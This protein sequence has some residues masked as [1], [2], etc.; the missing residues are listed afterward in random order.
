M[1]NRR[2]WVAEPLEGREL[3]SGLTF[4]LETDQTTYQVGQPIV[5]TFTETNGGDQP[6]TVEVLPTDFTVTLED[7]SFAAPVWQ[8]NPENQGAASTSEALQPGESLTQTVTWDGSSTELFGSPSDLYGTYAVTNPNAPQGTSASF[9]IASPIEDRLTTDQSTYQSGQPVQISFTRTNTSDQPIPFSLDGSE[10]LFQVTKDGQ[11]VWQSSQGP[12]YVFQPVDYPLILQPGQ[13]WTSTATWD[14][15]TS[16]AD[17]IDN[18]WAMGTSAKTTTG[19]FVVTSELDSA[20]LA[21]NFQIQSPLSYSL[22][23]S[24]L[25]LNYGQPNDLSYT[26]T[27]TS[28]QSVTFDMPPADFVVTWKGSAIWKSDPGAASEPTVTETLQPGQSLS[29]TATWEGIANEGPLANTDVFSSTQDYFSVS[30]PGL[31]AKTGIAF[32]IDDPLSVSV[33]LS[34]GTDPQIVQPGLPIQFTATETNTSDRPVTLLNTDGHFGLQYDTSIPAQS[35]VQFGVVH[36]ITGE[37]HYITIAASGVSSVGELVT[38]QPGQSQTFTATWDPSTDTDLPVGT[39]E[40]AFD[41]QNGESSSP[42]HVISI[43]ILAPPADSAP[44]QGSDGQGLI[45][46]TATLSTSHSTNGP[47][48]PIRI[49]LALENLSKSKVRVSPFS[50]RAEITLLRGSSVVATTRKRLSLAHAATVKPGR[51]LHLTTLLKLRPSHAA[52]R[53]LERGTYT[54]EV[55]DGGYIADTTVEIG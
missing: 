44:N 7:R 45:P 22:S 41:F 9:Q 28:D 49:T 15:W 47:S 2:A 21:A 36:V 33:T 10:D 20:A 6:E 14:G 37:T 30:V 8:S 48:D 3:L 16:A 18:F 34:T 31:P 12:P 23:E 5:M 32:A 1:R 35:V 11:I 38:L 39:S 53:T 43:D 17:T 24:H 13:S 54:I 52:L 51:S 25:S 29:A 46:L 40:Y 26:I 55:K 42:A 4:S 27:N 50:G 19:A